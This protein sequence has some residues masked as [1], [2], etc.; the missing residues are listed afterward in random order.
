VAERVREAAPGWPW[1]NGNLLFNLG[2]GLK[3]FRPCS[4]LNSACR[5]KSNRPNS[6]WRRMNIA[7]W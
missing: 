2:Q 5:R 1:N 6:S 7:A 4:G 3:D